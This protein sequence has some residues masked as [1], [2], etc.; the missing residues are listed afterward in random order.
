MPYPVSHRWTV[1][2]TQKGRNI[3]AKWSA[4]PGV[5][6]KKN[7]AVLGKVYFVSPEMMA[8]IDCYEDESNLYLR[9]EV[10]VKSEQGSLRAEV[11]LYNK[12][13]QG[14]LGRSCWKPKH[15][16]EIWYACYG[17]KISSTTRP[18]KVPSPNYPEVLRTALEKEAGL[19]PKEVKR[20]LDKA[21]NA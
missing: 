17:F 1:I 15:E 16:E 3:P 7:E 6:Q 20:Y 5:P 2:K 4:C 21:L 11:Y 12:S 19:R 13:T 14:C 10:R 18:Q 9:R 8:E